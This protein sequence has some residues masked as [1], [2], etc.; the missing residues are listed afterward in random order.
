MSHNVSI[1]LDDEILRELKE[2]NLNLAETVRK[3]LLE[4]IRKKRREELRKN[5]DLA[6]DLLK[7]ED[8][9]FYTRAVRETRNE[10]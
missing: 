2:L 6:K 1:R 4:E 5:L 3:A 8:V 9:D 10:R 7:S